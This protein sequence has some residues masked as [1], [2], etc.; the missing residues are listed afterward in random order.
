MMKNIKTF[1]DFTWPFS[2]VGFSILDRIR[3]ERPD[4]EYV[5]YPYQ[6]DEDI[7]EEGKDIF[8]MFEKGYERFSG[9]GKE[10]DLVFYDSKKVFNTERAHKAALFARD[11]DKFYEFA[12]EV[13]KT[14]WEKGENIGNMETLN[15]IG[16]EV[17]I[18]IAEMN[19][20]I[21]SGA[22]DEEM[23][24]AKR[25]AS[26]FEIESVPTFVVDDKKNVTNLKP[27]EEFVKDLE[28]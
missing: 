8:G 9:L 11:N 20:C 17:G 14:V 23:Y 22:Y 4:V 18:N 7:P 13:F 10:Y 1:M 26:V 21:S 12:K 15:N 5:W 16:L 28:D 2:Y 27:Y 3:K 19:R 24:E 6:L 25:M